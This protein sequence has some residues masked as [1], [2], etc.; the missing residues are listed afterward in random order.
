MKT[1]VRQNAPV[2]N[3]IDQKTPCTN[4]SNPP[5]PNSDNGLSHAM[6]NGP[7]VN[8]CPGRITSAPKLGRNRHHNHTS[9]PA[10]SPANA[11]IR[12]APRQNMPPNSA[13][14]NCATPEKDTSPMAAR[15][16]PPPEIRE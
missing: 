4:G 1:D 3:S 6:P 7:S 11:P 15:A 8:T 16:V 12:V 5:I 9:D 13:G 2:L 10:L 14:R